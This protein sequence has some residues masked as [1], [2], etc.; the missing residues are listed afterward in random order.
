[1]SLS[2]LLVQSE[3]RTLL[4]PL[5]CNSKVL[6]LKDLSVVVVLVLGI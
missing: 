3:Q 5:P 6:I 1:M 2:L 4:L